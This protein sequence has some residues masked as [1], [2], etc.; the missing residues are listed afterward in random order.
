[1]IK[2]HK[3]YLLLLCLLVFILGC[4]K[5]LNSEEFQDYILEPRNGLLQSTSTD[6]IKY[7][8][9]YKPVSLIFKGNAEIQNK[10]EY[11]DMHYFQLN[12]STHNDKEIIQL[13]K[14]PEQYEQLMKTMNSEIAQD[15]LLITNQ[16]DT[17]M[18]VAIDHSRF[19]NHGNSTSILMVFKS[20]RII[21]AKQINVKINKV[22][23][24]DNSSV[25]FNFKIK[26]I[27]NLPKLKLIDY[28]KHE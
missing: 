2:G 5:R 21:K 26:D 13:I 4:V 16:G 25:S 15:I 3:N 10:D 17:I 24:V 6:K 1:M 27:R 28:G 8:L 23:P 20:D 18:P 19:Y 9:L 22:W 12:M 7:Q 14:N 11:H